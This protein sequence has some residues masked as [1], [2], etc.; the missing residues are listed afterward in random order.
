M[1]ARLNLF[2]AVTVASLFATAAQ[3]ADYAPPPCYDAAIIAAGRAPPGAVPCYAP[4]PPV[5]EEFGG[6]YLRG[7]VGMSNQQAKLSHPSF[8]ERPYT[9]Q[10]DGFDSAPF[11]GAGVGYYFN[12]WLR[13]DVTG[14][15]RG[16]AN[17]HGYGTYPGGSDEYRARKK[18]WVGLLNAY[19][20]LGTWNRLTPFVGAGVGG[21]YNTVSSFLDINTPTGGV[22]SAQSGSKFNFAWALHAGFAYK[23]TP[24]FTVELAY[25][26]LDLGKAVTGNGVS[27]DG[28]NANGRP[29]EFDK[30]ISHDIMLG[31]R[32]NLDGFEMFSRPAP[33]YYAPAP[34]YSPPPVYVQPPLQSRG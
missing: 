18:E 21:A 33:V 29:F 11:F 7:Y 22:Y 16:S 32:F 15:Y 12:E 6:W 17:Y 10:D 25:R 20:D 13:F 2:A 28:T 34:V 27:F 19:V 3:A 31:L 30:L 5:V 8:N 23:V 9:H 1:V 24:N 14:E 26:Y 4:P